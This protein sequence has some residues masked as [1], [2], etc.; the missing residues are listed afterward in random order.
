MRYFEFSLESIYVHDTTK[1]VD[2]S[3]KVKDI[4]TRMYD[5]YV[6]NEK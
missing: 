1:A 5:A 6:E 3:L 2:L 4:L